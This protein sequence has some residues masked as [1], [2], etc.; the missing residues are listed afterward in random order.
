MDYSKIVSIAEIV[1]QVNIA[2]YYGSKETVTWG[3][4]SQQDYEFILM[5]RGIFVYEAEAVGSIECNPGEV[6][7]IPPNEEHVFT[8]PNTEWAFSCIH[9]LPHGGY[10]W[11]T[12][13]VSLDPAPEQIIDFSDNFVY[14][15]ALFHRCSDLF[16]SYEAYSTELAATCC[17]EIWLH[18]AARSPGD[19]QQVS[20]RM[21]V[22][23]AHIRQHMK[24][25]IDRNSL[26]AAFHI[27][28]EHVNYLF[29]RELGI[30]TSACINREKVIHGYH[31]LHS[32]GFSVSEAAYACGFTDPF[33]FSR[34]FKKILGIAP[35]TVRGRKYFT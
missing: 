30:S 27:S 28:P 25:R 20:D 1:P 10:P 32:Q 9:N 19:R 23:L 26:A 31:L 13:M 17:R 4:R 29:K 6:L 16:N 14:M 24:E 8:A 12:G 33:Y 15:D 3:S 34:V 2:N 22:I 35:D 21:K 5:R 7:I 18:C 11:F